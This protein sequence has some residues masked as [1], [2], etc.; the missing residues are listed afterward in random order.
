MKGP[1]TEVKAAIKE[2]H[3]AAEQGD[4]AA[5]Y[6]LSEIQ[7]NDGNKSDALEWLRKSALNDYPNACYTMAIFQMAGGSVPYDASA[8][9]ENVK[10]AAG[11]GHVEA[12]L[13]LS[14]LA[15]S[16]YGGEK[17]PKLA[18]EIILDL[19][20]KDHPSALCGVA[21]LLHIRNALSEDVEMLMDQAALSGSHIAAYIQAQKLR[22][23]ELAG[24]EVAR[25]KRI[26]NLFIAASGG[27]RL[28]ESE[29]VEYQKYLVENVLASVKR[30]N[31]S[32]VNLNFERIEE[33]LRG[34]VDFDFGEVEILSSDHNIRIVRQFLTLVECAYIR[35]AAA[36]TIQP[37]STIHP[38]TRRLVKSRI[39]TSSS[40]NF[41]PITRDCV[42]YAIDERIAAA[43]ATDV[44][45]G[46]PLNVLFYRIGEEY[47][48]HYDHLPDD[49][50]AGVTFLR[51]SGQR[52]YTFL[53]SISEDYL[54]GE[55]YFS[56]LGVSYRGGLGDALMF[57]N[58]H[59]D[60]TANM[61][62]RHA[63]MPLTEGNKWVASKWIRE[64]KFNFGT[65]AYLQTGL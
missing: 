22:A 51:Q 64:R 35:A 16:G 36:P 57:Q 11:R 49:G 23:A 39:R 13:L 61:L 6:A 31:R 8:A 62:M 45:Q 58:I 54:G 43:S 46:E 15:R 55:T 56:E 18:D 53:I 9:R 59:D 30:S 12:Q 3:R 5:Q 24:D 21:M 38:I 63:G 37:S 50:D 34:D 4:A 32:K 52:K 7:F 47:K 17:D 41:D 2:L 33:A 27:N 26:A 65:P 29:L 28:A 40:T 48:F 1:T 20:K 10:N 44:D 14:Q 42:I 60:G 25:N 19:A